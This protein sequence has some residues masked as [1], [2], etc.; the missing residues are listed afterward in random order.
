VKVNESANAPLLTI[1]RVVIANP[2]LEAMDKFNL[3]LSV[4]DLLVF[5]LGPALI[6]SFSSSFVV[7]MKC[8]PRMSAKELKGQK[9]ALF[10]RA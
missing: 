9:K 7:Q 2:N 6:G 5:V 10:D 1:S 4:T 8:H 3:E